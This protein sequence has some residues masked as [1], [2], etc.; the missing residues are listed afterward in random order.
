M[1]EEQTYTA[2]SNAQ[3]TYESNERLRPTSDLIDYAR[4]YA[5]EKPAVVALVCV[6]LGFV[7]GWKLKPW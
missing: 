4:R 5:R 7:L 2:A 6:G 1:I 3:A